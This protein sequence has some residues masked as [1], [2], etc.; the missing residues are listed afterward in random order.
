VCFCSVIRHQHCV[1]L[2]GYKVVACGSFCC[3][4]AAL[5][6]GCL[7]GWKVAALCAG[8]LGGWKVAANRPAWRIELSIISKFD[9]K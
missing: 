2:F 5:C 9:G 8:C 1:L 7:G 4:V 3:K 6:A